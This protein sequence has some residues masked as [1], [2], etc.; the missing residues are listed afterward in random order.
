VDIEGLTQNPKFH[1]IAA[2]SAV[3]NKKTLLALALLL[4]LY[5]TYRPLADN[6]GRS[7]RIKNK[8]VY[9]VTLYSANKLLATIGPGEIHLAHQKWYDTHPVTFVGIA[10]DDS[11]NIAGVFINTREGMVQS[12]QNSTTEDIAIETLYK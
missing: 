7:F 2:V 3:M 10:H 11:T 1:S 6:S 9:S 5:G 8:T 12:M 4:V